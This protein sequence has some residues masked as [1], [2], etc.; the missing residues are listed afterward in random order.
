M[1]LSQASSCMAVAPIGQVTREKD[2]EYKAFLHPHIRSDISSVL[3]CCVGWK[4]VS[5]PKTHSRGWVSTIAW[6]QERRSL[7]AYWN[8]PTIQASPSLRTLVSKDHNPGEMTLLPSLTRSPWHHN[9]LSKISLQIYW[10]MSRN[11]L[12]FGVSASPTMFPQDTQSK[13]ANMVSLPSPG[14]LTSS[15]SHSVPRFNKCLQWLLIS[16][17]EKSL[18]YSRMNF[19]LALC[20][21]ILKFK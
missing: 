1:S 6:I 18:P 4:Q 5:R 13:K 17:L 19:S 16:V 21:Q 9:A 8:L 3:P 14:S 11:W 7:G 20:P 15:C 10:H 12:Y 2:Q